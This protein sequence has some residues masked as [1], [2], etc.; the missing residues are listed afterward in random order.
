MKLPTIKK[1]EFIYIWENTKELSERERAQTIK[2][3]LE[4]HK[5]EE[6]EVTPKNIYSFVI[7]T[8]NF[9]HLEALFDV[10][11]SSAKDNGVVVYRFFKGANC[12]YRTSGAK[13]IIEN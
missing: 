12:T 2:K 3:F 10:Y 4:E 9:K 6:K 13:Y 7:A 5:G 1:D 11:L 8:Y